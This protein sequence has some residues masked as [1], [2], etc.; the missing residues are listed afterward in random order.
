MK[1]LIAPDKFKSVLSAQVV[2]DILADGIQSVF[3]EAQCV[4]KPMADG[5]DGTLNV[6]SQAFPNLIIHTHEIA[7]PLGEARVA[8]FAYLPETQQAV[9][10]WS[11]AAGLALVLEKER[12]PLNTT[13]L[14]VGQL[15]VAALAL[16][17]RE[18]IVALGGS[19]TC[20]AGIGALS[21][22]GFGF[23]D[24]R[25]LPVPLT[26]AG[27]RD[28]QTIQSAALPSNVRVTLLC[29]VESPFLGK[30]GALQYVKQKGA[31]LSD[32]VRLK[33][34][35]V[36]FADQLN[37]WAPQT[38]DPE[39]VSAPG[40]G[41]AGGAGLGF[42]ALLNASLKPGAAWIAQQLGLARLLP[43]IDWVIT[44][45]G[46][47][48]KQTLAGKAP[49]TVSRLAKDLSVPVI[50]IAG[51]IRV[52]VEDLQNQGIVAAFSLL[53]RCLSRAR[54][55]QDTPKLLLRMAKQLGGL[56]RATVLQ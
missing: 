36:N 16:G 12:H 26:G 9:I 48:D 15:M 22:L 38:W 20:D 10:A 17:A 45:E 33:A 47:L 8:R 6:L 7:G 51:E 40:T 28:I 13:S 41:A 21:A 55:M 19:A 4:V 43:E 30:Q 11:E 23:L 39:K 53:P 1:I 46:Q 34:G 25:G 14:G 44:G 56:L 24:G 52:P 50:A 29:D 42:S 18:L 5:G 32:K 54:A 2:A 37:R 49:V 31:T 27:L 35:F 3:S